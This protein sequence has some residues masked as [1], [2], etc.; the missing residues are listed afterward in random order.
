MF[1][2]YEQGIKYRGEKYSDGESSLN[3]SENTEEDLRRAEVFDALSHPT[4]ITILKALS[5]GALGFAD[6]KKKT[7]I[8]SSGHLQHH[9]SKLNGLVKTDEYGKYTL[10][11]QGKDALH[12]VETVEK[13]SKSEPRKN[14]TAH[15]FQSN[16]LLKLAVVALILLI[17]ATS[18]LAAF[19]YTMASSLQNSISERDNQVTQLNNQLNQLNSTINQR[20]STLEQRDTF[21]LQLGTALNLSQSLIGINPP[22]SSQY[23]KTS[24]DSNN[25]GNITKIFLQSSTA[26]YHYGPAYPFN[27]PWFNATGGGS[28]SSQRAFELTNNRSISLSFW[29]WTIGDNGNYSYGAVSGGGVGEHPYLM[30]GVT[31]RNDYNSTD[32]GNGSDP[33]APIGKQTPYYESIY[34][35]NT[36]YVSFVNL[37]VKLIGQDGSVILADEPG[38]QSPPVRGGQYFPLGSGET[39]QVVFYFYP[40]SLDIGSFEIS[41][42][43]LSSV[44]P[45]N[46]ATG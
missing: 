22:N 26:W 27:T 31:V 38:I 7:G 19:E 45:L 39:K 14:Y 18:T 41:V 10:S 25:E 36:Q 46:G 12:T 43:Y 30:I 2:V 6:L 17:I 5:E 3:D 1:L 32:A 35:L 34:H 29:G 15:S 37:Y 44:P 20:D 24:P 42:S 16:I 13:V 8:E 33:K 4:R 11:D 28:F 23:L 9:L 40:S 21:I